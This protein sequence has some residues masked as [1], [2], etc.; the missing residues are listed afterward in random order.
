MSFL[1]KL[2]IVTFI[3]IL[4]ILTPSYSFI[5]KKDIRTYKRLKLQYEWINIDLYHI[6]LYES[7]IAKFD[8]RLIV[9]IIDVESSGQNIIS[10][11]NSNGSRDYGVMQINSAHIKKGEERLYLNY[12]INIAKGISYFK[13]CMKQSNYFIHE[14]IRMYNAGINSKKSNNKKYVQRIFHNYHRSL[15]I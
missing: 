5:S 12:N 10:K 2:K 9:A 13:E 8:P 15:N 3:S 4:L 11:R 7:K 6:I 14:S 1:L